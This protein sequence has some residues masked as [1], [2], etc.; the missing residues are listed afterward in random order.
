MASIKQLSDRKY[1]IT[2]SNGYRTDGRKICKAKTIQVPDSV[3]KRGVEQYVYHEAERLERLF[4]QGYDRREQTK[5]DYVFRRKGMKLP[6]TPSTF[7]WRFKKILKAND[8]P[9]DLNVHSLR[10][11]AATLFIASG[12]D[13]GTVAGLLGHS[14]P[15]TTLDIYTH[16]FDKNKK[17]ASQIMQSSLE[18]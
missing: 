5:D 18:I 9:T 7:T 17:T 10:H 8:L 4:K 15:S 12:T 14:Q 6:M 1:K 13:V 2:I 16:A 11:T 3:P